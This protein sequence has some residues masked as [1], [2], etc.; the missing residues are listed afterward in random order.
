M[1]RNICLIG[2]PTSGKS[3]LGR[4]LYKYYN[5]GYI[6]TDDILVNKYKQSLPNLITNLGKDEFLDAEMNCIKDIYHNNVVLSTGGSVIYRESSIHHIKDILKAD[7]YHLKL[8]ENEF[9]KRIKNPIN[10]G[11]VYKDNQSMKD[12]YKERIY[13]YDTFADYIINVDSDINL[14]KFKVS[15]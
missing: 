3:K 12:L 2:L 5:K 6:D 11:V 1:F 14:D 9:L 4:K 8:S 7:I 13:F 15:V 10:R